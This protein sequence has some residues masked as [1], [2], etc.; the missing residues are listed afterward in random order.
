[1][2]EAFDWNGSSFV[3]TTAYMMNLTYDA[4][5]NILTMTRNG[6]GTAL[7][8][9]NL[10]YRYSNLAKPN[11]LTHID[12][13]V[14]TTPLP[15]DL[16][17]QAA[18]NY[19][20]DNI[21]NMITDVSEGGKTVTWNVYNKIT[22]VSMS[23][24]TKTLAFGYDANGNR[25]RKESTASSVN[26][27]QW[28]VRDAQGNIL[29]VYK[30]VG[31]GTL[32]QEYTYLYGSTRVGEYLL[33]RDSVAP[34]NRHYYRVKG[35]RHYEL[36]NHLGNVLAVVTDRKMAKDTTADATYTPQFF[37][38][39]VYSV[40]NYYA[41]GQNMPKWSNTTAVND[42]KKYKFG[43]NG[44]EDDDEWGKQDY[45][46]RIYDARVGRFLSVDPL[47][48]DYPELTNYQFASNSPI[49]GIDLDG[50]EYFFAAD[51][52]F[53]GRVGAD[54]KVRIANSGK[55]DFVAKYV[56][57]TNTAT[58]QKDKD[59][60]SQQILSESNNFDLGVKDLLDRVHMAYGEGAAT[61][62][63]TL[64][65]GEQKKVVDPANFF[66]D[67]IQN[68]VDHFG[69]EEVMKNR[70]WKNSTK[71]YKKGTIQTEGKSTSDYNV[72]NDARKRFEGG[73][74]NAFS[75]D[76]FRRVLGATIS[77]VN[78]K[79]SEDAV[80]GAFQWVGGGKGDTWNGLVTGRKPTVII[81]T[82][83]R[84]SSWKGSDAKPLAFLNT[85]TFYH[86]TQNSQYDKP[87][88]DLRSEQNKPK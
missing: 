21:G 68:G 27:K 41:F 70:M 48:G 73:D 24:G 67:A 66:A 39:D 80:H 85:T 20:Y 23:S 34:W 49:A 5:G 45:G 29:S 60:N 26:T 33:N 51:G 9:D 83:T 36:T 37:M 71:S 86:L 76:A 22:A 15:D 78:N 77:A 25:V 35:N 10:T 31:S 79:S 18:N 6:D 84:W 56:K 69:S 88:E 2:Q 57:Y 30:Q 32:R 13:A 53:L 19:V 72:F 65:D 63:Y 82:A 87:G 44:K 14:A 81:T 58:N 4:G 11:R 16:E 74:D 59:W 54:T 40:Q 7:S 38:P 8:M 62:I 12:D 75:S 47:S 43:F 52:R 61:D 28:Y 55:E 46:F 64:G 50:L 42:P 17:D 3:G 1:M